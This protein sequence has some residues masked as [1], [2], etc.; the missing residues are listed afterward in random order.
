MC[1]MRSAVGSHPDDLV[2]LMWE[3]IMENRRF[4]ITELR[5]HFPP[6][7]AENCHGAPVVQKI[8]HQTGAK[9]TDTR[10]Q[11]KAHGVSIDI[12]IAKFRVIC[13]MI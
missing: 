7:V 2:E 8:V 4:T 3:H 6:F 13:A 11:T 1:L 9:A 5:S 10:T 12:S